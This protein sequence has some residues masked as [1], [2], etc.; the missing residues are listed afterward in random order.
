MTIFLAMKTKSC[1]TVLDNVRCLLPVPDTRVKGERRMAH[2]QGS[3][4]GFQLVC[5]PPA[6]SPFAEKLAQMAYAGDDECHKFQRDY[7]R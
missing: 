2:Y 1:P 3:V 4:K 6:Y 5:E 7:F